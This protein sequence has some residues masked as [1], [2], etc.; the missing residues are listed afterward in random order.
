MS[1]Y[2]ILTKNVRKDE[3]VKEEQQLQQPLLRQSLQ[4]TATELMELPL[5]QFYEEL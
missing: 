4:Y 2:S 1:G 3:R 5:E